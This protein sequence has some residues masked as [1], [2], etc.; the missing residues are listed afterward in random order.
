MF[1][2]KISNELED[3]LRVNIYTTIRSS[4]ITSDPMEETDLAN[5][6]YEVIRQV[7]E[8]GGMI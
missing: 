4:E 2:I 5:N 3:A 8:E 7:L 1:N 6:I